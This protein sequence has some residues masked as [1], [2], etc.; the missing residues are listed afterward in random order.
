[1]HAW[2]CRRCST[3]NHPS[4]AYCRRCGSPVVAGR[5]VHADARPGSATLMTAPPAAAPVPARPHAGA[6]FFVALLLALIWPG[7]GQIY[8]G[9]YTKGIALAVVGVA[10]PLVGFVVMICAGATMNNLPEGAGRDAVGWLF[11]GFVICAAV[12]AIAILF[13][14]VL[15]ALRISRREPVRPGQWF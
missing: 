6:H 14:A 4:F 15:I 11:F 5:A 3:R 13:D 10:T 2:D 8:N 9:Q 1:M 7:F 12:A